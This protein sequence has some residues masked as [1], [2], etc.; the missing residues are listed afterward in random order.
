MGEVRSLERQ[1]RKAIANKDKKESA[2]IL[3]QFESKVQKVA[4]KGRLP[5]TTASRKVSRL[6]KAIAAL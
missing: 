3:V 5:K 6:S 1:V 4:R 2:T